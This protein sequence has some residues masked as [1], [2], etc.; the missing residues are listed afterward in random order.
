M[1]RA[2]LLFTVGILA[3]EVIRRAVPGPPFG[4]MSMTALLV[5][6]FIWLRMSAMQGRLGPGRGAAGGALCGT[7]IVLLPAA[8]IAIASAMKPAG[9]SSGGPG[10]DAGFVALVGAQAVMVLVGA[11][12]GALTA[13]VD[14]RRTAGRE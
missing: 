6:P 2:T 3:F 4:A 14:E 8:C 10:T 13:L 1:W 12:L 11:C 5:F 9:T 7:V